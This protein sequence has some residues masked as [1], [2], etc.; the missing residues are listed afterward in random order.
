MGY[1][2]KGFSGFKNSPIRQKPELPKGVSDTLHMYNQQIQY[3]DKNISTKEDY[4]ATQKKL[5]EYRDWREDVDK[6]GIRIPDSSNE[7]GEYDLMDWKEMK[8]QRRL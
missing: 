8:R 5:Y 2:M 6:R 4:D 3:L 7:P 1:K